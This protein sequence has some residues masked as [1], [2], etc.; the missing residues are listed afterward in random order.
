MRP[1]VR[2]H[3]VGILPHA[4]LP[5][6]F[7]SP[8]LLLPRPRPLRR[9][10]VVGQV[11]DGA[12]L[13][14]IIEAGISPALTVQYEE[15]EPEKQTRIG[16]LVITPD[17]RSLYVVRKEL[18]DTKGQPLLRPGQSWG[19]SGARKVALDGE[20]ITDR[21]RQISERKV[22]E[23]SEPLRK[24]IRELE[25]NS[26]PT[27]E[28]K[29]IRFAIEA[30]RD[31]EKLEPLVSQLFPYAREF[32]EAVKNEVLDALYEV[33]SRTRNGMTADVAEAVSSVLLELLPIGDGG[34]LYRSRRPITVRHHEI[35]KRVEEQ[36]F[37]ITHD[38]A[39]ISEIRLSLVWERTSITT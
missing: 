36:A 12:T 21:F 35:L 26:G 34:L 23:A 7:L 2:D 31:W 3:R 28:V 32:G 6:V 14:Q 33:T 24:R 19:R 30:E 15:L 1:A 16:V 8:L 9:G 39:A 29:R 13:G 25:E 27:L 4:P 5:L 38:V 17:P 20:A 10:V 22:Q 11:V 37:N 18:R